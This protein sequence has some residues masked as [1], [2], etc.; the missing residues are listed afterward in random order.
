MN[1]N[2]IVLFSLALV[3]FTTET[4]Q[5]QAIMN[6]QDTLTFETATV[7]ALRIPTPA[8]RV[9]GNVHSITAITLQNG[10]S[11]DLEDALNSLP[12]VRMET[13]GFGG[14]RRLQI[15]SSGI[16]A[17]FAVR[18][19]HMLMDGF[20]LTNASGISPL[21]LWNPQWMSRL[22]VLKGPAGAIYGSGYG[23]VLL[24]ESLGAM[25]G[26]DANSRV[27]GF[28]RVA[29]S[30]SESLSFEGISGEAG[31][32]YQAQRDSVEWTLR[33]VWSQT[34]GDREHQSNR[35][36][37]A[38][39]HRRKGIS[40]A[41]RTHLWAGWMDASWDLPGSLNESDATNSPSTSPGEEYDAHVDRMRTW[42][43]WS[44]Q[45]ESGNH[46]SGLWLYVQHSEKENPF[47]TSPFFNGF[48]DETEQFGS[49]RGWRAQTAM[50]SNGTKITWDQTAIIRA[51]R[52]SL[53]ESDLMP[54]DALYRYDIL[55]NTANAWAS[56]GLRLERDTWQLDI[57]TALEWMKRETEGNGLDDS[58]SDAPISEDYEH[59]SVLPYFSISRALTKN[60]R[61]FLQYGKA[62]SHP[63][64]FELVDPDTYAALNL[65]P[66][67][68]NAIELGWKGSRTTN[69]ATFNY[70]VQGYHQIIS[71]AIASV[72]GENDGNYIDNV[73]GL[74][75]SGAEFYAKGNFR[76]SDGHIISIQG[77]ASLNRHTFENVAEALPGTPLHSSSMN[78]IYV[79]N[80]WSFG[81]MHFWNDKMPLHNT[82]DDW[83]RAHHRLDA[84]TAFSAGNGTWQVGIRNLLNAQYSSW[85]QTNWFGGKYYNPA[86]ARMAWLSWKWVVN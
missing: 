57:Q 47:G 62:S 60:T 50:L 41:N 49:M 10:R 56:T 55:S 52:L 79:A 32:Q 37:Q 1:T 65:L 82:E 43:G 53:I 64:T 39:L 61:A 29:T 70:S 25:R 68:A 74:M 63:T 13:R 78:T 77:Q 12:G 83:S 71:D 17:P 2:R 40:T 80:K 35:R 11:P 66:E 5:S 44:S 59:L 67:R 48:K 22:E 28:T 18:N 16:R 23:G 7:Q 20:V 24:G 85:H 76:I 33:G 6:G 21:D 73:E 58:D 84:W 19:V 81:L 3:F 51:E 15:R 31:F 38:E 86:P 34:P 14:S 8:D 46:K 69:K 72:P 30:G 54:T 27:T 42:L 36:N 75:M 4:L 9:G 26:S 45:K